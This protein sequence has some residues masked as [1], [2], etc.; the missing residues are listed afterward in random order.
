ME[1]GD[2]YN[3]EF[4]K[5]EGMTLIRG[6]A[7]PDGF[8]HLVSDIIVKH[9]DGTYFWVSDFFGVLECTNIGQTEL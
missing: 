4:E 9:V 1:V 6:E 5:I 7:I 3:K 2:A 8:Y